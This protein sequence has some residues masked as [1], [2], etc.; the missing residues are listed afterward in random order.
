MTYLVCKRRQACLMH[1]QVAKLNFVIT[2]CQLGI[3]YKFLS[4]KR[5]SNACLMHPSGPPYFISGGALGSLFYQS[6]HGA[7]WWCT[8]KEFAFFFLPLASSRLWIQNSTPTHL[9]LYTIIW[10]EMQAN[11]MQPKWLYGRLLKNYVQIT[12]EWKPWK[13]I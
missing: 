12:T 11:K 7:P 1:F 8:L 4:S 13:I 10:P 3:K 5:T 9:C 6:C 2:I